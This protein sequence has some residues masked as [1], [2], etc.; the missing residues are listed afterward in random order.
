[1]LL[2]ES[3]TPSYRMYALKMSTSDNKE[4][5]GE[6]HNLECVPNCTVPK[7]VERECLD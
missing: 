5:D 3:D 1:M 6:C 2:Q 7:I 4:C